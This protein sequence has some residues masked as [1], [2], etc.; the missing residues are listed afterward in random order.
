LPIYIYMEYSYLITRTVI[1]TSNC[2]PDKNFTSVII[3]LLEV[4][5]MQLYSNACTGKEH[6]EVRRPN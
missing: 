2:Q 6:L 3:S 5:S 1:K 4:P